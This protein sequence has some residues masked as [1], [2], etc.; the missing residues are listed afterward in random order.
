MESLAIQVYLEKPPP[1]RQLRLVDN[2]DARKR[3]HPRKERPIV[4]QTIHF[5]IPF[6]MLDELAQLAGRWAKNPV[7]RNDLHYQSV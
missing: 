1:T 4:G 7:E 2:S 6:V 3:S 5:N